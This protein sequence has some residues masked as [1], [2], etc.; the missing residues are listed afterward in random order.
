VLLCQKSG[1]QPGD[2]A[3]HYYVVKLVHSGAPN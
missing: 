3:P 1:V 2:A